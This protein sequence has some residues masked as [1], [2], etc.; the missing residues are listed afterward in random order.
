MESTIL[1]SIVVGTSTLLGVAL[2][3]FVQLRTQRNNQGFQLASETSRRE[4]ENAEKE[5][6]LALDRL[7]TAHRQLSI[8]G[9]EFSPTTLDIIW[10]ADMKDLEYD[11]RYL[12]VCR[13]VDE[14]RVIAGLFETSLSEDVEKISCQMNM[15]WG[16]FKNVLRL[17]SLGERPTPNISGLADAHAAAREI[18]GRTAAIKTQLTDLAKRYRALG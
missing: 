9:R 11:Q 3:A 16:N 15:F 18:G 7:A 12:S 13:E 2:T 1:T 17:N 6:T 8:I 5:K 4:S 10:R 14:L